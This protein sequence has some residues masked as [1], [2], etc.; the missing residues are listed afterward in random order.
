MTKD[1]KLNLVLLTAC[2]LIY[3]C[4]L[5]VKRSPWGEDM[6]FLRF[7]LN[8]I[9]A[10]IALLSYINIRLIIMGRHSINK[11]KHVI[12]ICLLCSLVWEICGGLLNVNSTFDY[13]DI[14]CYFCGGTLYWII[15]NKLPINFF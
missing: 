3:V 12:F 14:I 10:P 7:Y 6:T 11:I 1:K 15:I 13:L 5:W 4:N 2:I 8:D 9:L